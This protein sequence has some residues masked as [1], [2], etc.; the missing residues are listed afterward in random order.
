MVWVSFLIKHT[1]KEF[2]YGGLFLTFSIFP[3]LTSIV[4]F[5]LWS[6]QTVHGW[7]IA[8]TTGSLFFM[9]VFQ[10]LALIMSGMHGRRITG[11]VGCIIIGNV[12]LGKREHHFDDAN[13][14]NINHHGCF[15]YAFRHLVSLFLPGNIRMDDSNVL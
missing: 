15:N 12:F 2:I 4:Y 1:A 5:L 3:L 7:T 11:T 9:Y 10:G 13:L 8:A 6:R 14:R